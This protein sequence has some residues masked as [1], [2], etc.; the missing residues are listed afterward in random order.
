MIKK[1]LPDGNLY[2]VPN[3]NLSFNSKDINKYIDEIY[4]ENNP[5]YYEKYYKIKKGMTV[6]DA[7][8]YT[9]I[10]TLRA[11]KIVGSSGI[12]IALEPFLPSFNVLKYNII[13]NEINNVIL[14]NEGIGNREDYKTI[15][16]KNQYI[17]ASIQKDYNL[18]ILKLLYKF[19]NKY[20]KYKYNVNSFNV[21]ITTL[22]QLIC[23]Y[24]LLHVS[25]V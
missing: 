7:G 9:G 5:H 17:G 10:F 24:K 12:V 3:K 1:I 6:I 18:K 2:Y 19:W 15:I 21:K 13:K 23:K 16:I 25:P 14:L 20:C 8:A 4:N 22:D 11:S